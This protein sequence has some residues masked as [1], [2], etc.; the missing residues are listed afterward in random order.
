MPYISSNLYI[1]LRKRLP[2][3]GGYAFVYAFMRFVAFP[4]DY[5]G[6]L[7]T[8]MASRGGSMAI[9]IAAHNIAMEF[10]VI[11]HGNTMITN[12]NAMVY[13]RGLR[14]WNI[15]PWRSVVLTWFAMKVHDNVMGCDDGSWEYNGVQLGFMGFIDMT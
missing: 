5:H 1:C 15:V 10:V 6:L 14:Q 8:V 11:H 13:H 3:L 12:G 9:V 4:I 7:W 2:L